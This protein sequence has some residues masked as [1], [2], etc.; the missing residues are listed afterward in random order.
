M[1]CLGIGLAAAGKI[2]GAGEGDKEDKTEKNLGNA[3]YSIKFGNNTYDLSWI[4]PSAVPLFEGVEIYNKYAKNKD[5]NVGAMVDTFFGALNPVTDMSVL[6]SIERTLTTLAYGKNAVQSLGET[7]FSSYLSQYIPTFFSQVAQVFDSKQRNSNTG[8]NALEKTRDQIL[9][10]IPFLRNTLPEKVDIWG[11]TNKTA[12]NIGQRAFEAFI[13]PANR[14][15][16]RVDKTTKELERLAR[17]TDDTAVLPTSKDKSVKINGE[18]H[19]LKGKDFV[20][21]Q[22]TYG[23]TAKKNLD[24]LIESDSYKKASDAEKKSMVGK[25]YDYATYKAKENYA[26]NKGINFDSGK[27]TAFAMIDAFN[28]P[29]E[30][31]VE[32]RVSGNE[33]ASKTLNKLNGAG[34]TEVQKGAV[35]NYFNRAYYVDGEKL[36]N[37]L[38]NSGLSN[39]QKELIKAKY[40]KNIT[41]SERERYKRADTMGVDYDLYTN[42]RNFVSNTKGESRTGGLTK[43]QKV[44]NWIQKQKLSAKQKQNLYDDYINNQRTFS[45]YN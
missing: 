29:Y 23:K 35:M 12:E 2:K 40:E 28:I 17:E 36:Y 44:I 10:K 7:T 22:K 8:T 4:S 21:L 45:Y 33:S 41:D 9:Y 16:Y 32:N 37:T 38:K 27:Q 24:K 31:Y 18:E 11:E 5:V 42:F 15:E 43:K 14:K 39:K 34:L 1:L 25:L 13:S 26:K 19:E 20:D 30:K 3:Q 6:Q